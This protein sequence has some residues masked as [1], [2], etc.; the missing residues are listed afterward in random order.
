MAASAPRLLALLEEGASAEVVEE[1]APLHP[2]QGGAY[3]ANAGELSA[4]CAR[5]A[6]FL[7]GRSF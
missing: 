7:A 4:L 3:F 1:F 6:P 2:D 5:C